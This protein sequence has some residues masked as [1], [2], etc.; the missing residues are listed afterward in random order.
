MEEN[1]ENKPEEQKEGT[2]ETPGTDVQVQ[3][4]ISLSD[5]M[6]GVF[7]EPRATFEGVRDSKKR[8]Y[9]LVP[10][11][12][13]IIFTIVAS[14]LVINDEE[15]YSEIKQMQRDAVV[16]RME[17]Q[18]KEGKMTQEQMDQAVERT[19]KFMD[20]SSPFFLISTI[21]GPLI[22]GFIVL[23]LRALV[24]WL[25]LKILKGVASYMLVVCVTA[26]SGLIDVISTVINTVLA[27]I[28]GRLM[29]NIGPILL[30]AKD[31]MSE[32]MMKFVSH[33]DLITIWYLIILGIGLSAVSGL[34]NSKTMPMVFVLWIIWVCIASFAGLTFIR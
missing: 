7:T 26:L 18:V 10:T 15:L 4:D 12:I 14:L 19:E 13:V 32:N 11:I 9:W 27:I 33:F 6:T 30:F 2:Q 29:V 16:K 25:V 3:E 8:S 31:S 21:L 1:T 17:E 22:G 28:T 34:K 24:I 20:K 23:F 5:A